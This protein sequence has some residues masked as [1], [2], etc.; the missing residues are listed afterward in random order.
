MRQWKGVG[1]FGFSVE[2]CVIWG[3]LYER[4]AKG[5]VS[6]EQRYGNLQCKIWSILLPL[7]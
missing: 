5:G 3:W 1:R 6:Y 4:T 2:D 7:I